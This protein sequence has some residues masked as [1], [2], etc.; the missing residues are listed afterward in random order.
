MSGIGI[1][2]VSKEDQLGK[3]DAE[4]HNKGDAVTTHLDEFF[5]NNGPEPTERKGP[6]V[7]G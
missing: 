6:A 1:D 5:G 2:G 3:G 7:H 4:H